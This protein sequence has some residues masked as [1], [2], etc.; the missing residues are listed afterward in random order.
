[1]TVNPEDC[2]TCGGSRL[3]MG[4]WMGPTPSAPYPDPCQ[5]CSPGMT[6]RE[7]QIAQT[8]WLLDNE[9]L[10]QVKEMLSRMAVFNAG[11]LRLVVHVPY[12]REPFNAAVRAGSGIDMQALRDADMVIG[13]GN[14]VYKDRNR[15]SGYVLSD[16][17]L[18]RIKD[19][20]GEFRIIK[21][22]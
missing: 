6:A 10:P 1:M 8:Q 17:E 11:Q 4:G 13:Q 3:R 19:E 18:R 2:P 14:T 9:H 7:R 16:N 5:A 15:P 12:T 22:L 20:A 21:S